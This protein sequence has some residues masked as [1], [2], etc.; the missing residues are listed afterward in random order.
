M[1]NVGV[2]KNLLA[3]YIMLRNKRALF[4]K[5]NKLEGF[6]LREILDIDEER[7][8]V[9]LF[10]Y[11]YKSHEMRKA[12]EPFLGWIKDTYYEKYA[13]DYSVEEFVA[14]CGVY[15]L[16]QDT[17]CSYIKTGKARRVFDVMAEEYDYET[18]RMIQSLCS[19]LEYIAEKKPI[20]FAIDKVF[21]AP[22]SV[23]RLIN[24]M[25]KRVRN[26]FFI[27]IYDE[28]YLVKEYCRPQWDILMNT[29]DENNMILELSVNEKQ[30]GVRY[31]DEFVCKEE[32]IDSYIE[33]LFNM[34]HTFASK[35]AMYYAKIISEF[36]T[37]DNKNVTPLQKFYIYMA[38]ANAEL[39][40]SN[41]KNVIYFCEKM[42]PLLNEIKNLRSD[43]VYNY[44]MAKAQ[45]LLSDS[46]SAFRFC[47]QCRNIAK[48]LEDEK[49]I[50]NVDVI[51]TVAHYGT[52]KEMFKCD[53]TYK[54]SEDIIERLKKYKHENFLAYVYAYSFENDEEAVMSIS[55][56]E[57]ESIYFSKAIEIG[58]R[59]NN[60]NFLL[61]AYMKNVILYSEYGRYDYVTI[62]YEKRLKNLDKEN[63]VRIAHAYS[64][65]AYNSLVLEEYSKADAYLKQGM[66]IL[67]DEKCAEDL[68]ETLYNMLVN[69]F[70]AGCNEKT[71]ECGTLLFKML[72]LIGI[73]S[74]QICN[75]SKLYGFVV[76]AYYK[77]GQI[78]DCYYYLNKMEITMSYILGC[79]K[80]TDRKLW[81]SDLCV[82]YLCKA[83]MSM[84]EEQYEEAEEYFALA[85]TYIKKVEGDRYYSDMEYA[86]FISQLYDRQNRGDEKQKVLEE[87]YEYYKN[88]NYKQ[89]AECVKAMMEGRE[90]KIPSEFANEPLPT[91]AILEMCELYGAKKMIED[92]EKD[93]NFLA[94]CHETM[95]SEQDNV[96]DMVENAATIIQNS[97]N[98]NRLILLEKKN[99]KYT[100]TYSSGAIKLNMKEIKEVFDFFESY[101]MEFISSRIDNSFSMY[102]ELLNKFNTGIIATAVGI[103]IFKDDELSRVFIGIADVH[104]AFTAN[105]KFLNAHNLTIM[106]YAVN[107]LSDSIKRIMNNCMINAMNSELAKS[108][109]TDQLTGI[110]NRMGLDKLV[111]DGLSEK[112]AL[113]YLDLDYF[114]KY[115]DTYGHD[116]GDLILKCFANIL[117]NNV[118]NIGYAIRYG[119][120]EFVAIIPDRDEAFAK[121]LATN[122][123]EEFKENYEVK[124]A[125]EGQI[126]SASIGVAEYDDSSKE[127]IEQGLKAA[128]LALYEVKNLGRGRVIGW[129]ELE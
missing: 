65:L 100:T 122:I 2:V 76:L 112:G 46:D 126:I 21:M 34:T 124:M 62:M 49:L 18:D 51:E 31:P 102:E 94:L 37:R 61:M 91:K 43:Y 39:A 17:I 105:K 85:K 64:G 116:T 80:E 97:F 50:M 87:T 95:G 35:D 92:R 53:Y 13:E 68:A 69:Y 9:N 38:M 109:V 10:C 16:Q 6:S 84:Y 60:K 27:F 56:G 33:E 79:D 77:L 54:V 71:V 40:L 19:A 14:N 70:V 26:I 57:R 123:N 98:L 47:K 90:Y 110:Y 78:Y 101:R 129:S 75:T 12:F 118:K 5:Q 48:K 45:L 113:L 120:D 119:G 67:M 121:K 11:E 55:N 96:L 4:V 22:Y 74:I 115:N 107:Q 28:N 83:N 93:V 88:K 66:K 1:S 99:D 42:V 41:H 89:R 125:I 24:Y 108:A 73:H 44:L 114:K 58:E 104:R 127:G 3:S 52:M 117:E 32:L 30:S 8:Y 81:Y 20:V 29:A 63:P 82:Y 72:E 111:K 7:N 25:M 86:R 36:I 106:K 15:S 128:D 23:L 103:P 59:L